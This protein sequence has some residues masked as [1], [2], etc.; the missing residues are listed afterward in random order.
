MSIV[1]RPVKRTCA[2]PAKRKVSGFLRSRARAL[3]PDLRSPRPPPPPFVFVPDFVPLLPP[4][5]FP[6][7]GKKNGFAG[8]S[9]FSACAVNPHEQV[10]KI[11]REDTYRV[12]RIP[13][14]I[15]RDPCPDFISILRERE[16]SEK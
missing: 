14:Q 9:S 7:Y 13:D 16:I 8:V 2:I 3:F 12:S 11:E 4:I 6:D 15:S 1:L 5:A 10:E